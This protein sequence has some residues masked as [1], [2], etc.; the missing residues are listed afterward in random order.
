MDNAQK[1]YE[2]IANLS[3]AMDE[4]RLF[5]DTHPDDRAALTAHDA[6]RRRRQAAVAQYERAAGPINFYSA[7]GV[8]QWN[9]IAQPW[10]WETE[11]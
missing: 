11:A 4:L 2:E 10:P 5:L 8:R 9:W 1:L 7:G 6:M 3:F